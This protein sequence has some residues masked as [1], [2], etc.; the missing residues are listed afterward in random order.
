MIPTTNRKMRRIQ[1]IYL[2]MTLYHIHKPLD[3]RQISQSTG[4]TDS[5]SESSGGGVPLV[6]GG[7]TRALLGCGVGRARLP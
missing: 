5:E 6:P 7:G 3:T 1:D 4:S 2:Y